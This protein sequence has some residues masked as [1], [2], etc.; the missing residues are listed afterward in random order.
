MYFQ[1][2]S[3]NIKV[4]QHFLA[5]RFVSASTFYRK[6]QVCPPPQILIISFLQN[7]TDE[8]ISFIVLIKGC[9]AVISCFHLALAH[10]EVLFSSTEVRLFCGLMFGSSSAT[11]SVHLCTHPKLCWHLNS[12]VL[13]YPTRP[14]ET[15]L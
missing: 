6:I 12:T 4:S 8:A 14:R 11:F 15:S 3:R 5:L 1:S 10:G 2:F 7:N 9:E 13:R